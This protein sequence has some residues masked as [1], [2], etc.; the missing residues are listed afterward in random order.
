MHPDDDAT[1]HLTDRELGLRT[2]LPPDHPALRALDEAY[3]SG[4]LDPM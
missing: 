2:I 3:G 4:K 1:P